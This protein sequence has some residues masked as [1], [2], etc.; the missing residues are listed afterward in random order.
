M[1]SVLVVFLAK[2]LQFSFQVMRVS[3]L[4]TASNVPTVL[5][6]A[7]IV[8]ALILLYFLRI[9]QTSARLK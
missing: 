1:N 2:G 4:L 5:W 7:N 6:S 3:A 9:V 8:T